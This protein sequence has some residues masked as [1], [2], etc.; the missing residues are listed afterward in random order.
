MLI[1]PVLLEFTAIIVYAHTPK[2][3]TVGD[4]DGIVVKKVGVENGIIA[5]KFRITVLETVS[6]I[7]RYKVTWHVD[8]L[9]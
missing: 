4:E 3:A 5:K 7:V 8:V 6:A 2:N 9:T 1:K